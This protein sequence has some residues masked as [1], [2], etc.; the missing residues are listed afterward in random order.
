VREAE[1]LQA[2]MALLDRLLQA[3]MAHL[4]ELDEKRRLITDGIADIQGPSE[5]WEDYIAEIDDVI[6]IARSRVDALARHRDETQRTL[7]GVH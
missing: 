7:Q 3:E 1:K 4:Q 6:R 5:I 2:E